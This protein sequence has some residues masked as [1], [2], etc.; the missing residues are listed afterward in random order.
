MSNNGNG[1]SR[2]TLAVVINRC[3]LMIDN[4]DIV[5]LGETISMKKSTDCQLPKSL[6][7]TTNGFHI[8]SKC[9]KIILL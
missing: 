6:F 8:A 9:L 3:I 1:K 2:F 5:P 7:C 4:I